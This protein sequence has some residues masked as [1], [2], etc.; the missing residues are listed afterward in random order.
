MARTGLYVPLFNVGRS[1]SEWACET[2]VSGGSTLRSPVV[3]DEDRPRVSLSS[4]GNTKFAWQVIVHFFTFKLNFIQVYDFS[5]T[6]NK[7]RQIHN[8]SDTD[9]NVFY[10]VYGLN[11]FIH[12]FKHMQFFWS[13]TEPKLKFFTI[14]II[15][16]HR[17]FQ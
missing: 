2:I 10:F 5:S 11:L 3:Y 1:R 16:V 13:P 9:T 15:V 4:S 7:T 6:I 14:Q 17:S 12:K 8:V